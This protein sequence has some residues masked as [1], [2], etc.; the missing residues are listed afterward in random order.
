MKNYG[1]RNK[2]TGEITA[3]FEDPIEAKSHIRNAECEEVA[4]RSIEN[5]YET[6]PD[7]K[8]YI[9]GV[10]ERWKTFLI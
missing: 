2:I 7:G 1:I 5:V 3:R 10:E 9:T 8:T 6:F 4:E